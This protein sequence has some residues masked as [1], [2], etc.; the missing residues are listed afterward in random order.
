MKRGVRGADSSRVHQLVK[1][2]ER[3]DPK[4]AAGKSVYAGKTYYFCS[5]N[6]K[7][8]FDKDPETYLK[9]D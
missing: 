2:S 1:R 7:V 4:T 8:A 3:A 6:E 5:K 9:Q